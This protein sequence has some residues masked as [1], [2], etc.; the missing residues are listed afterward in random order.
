MKALVYEGP[1]M[2]NIHELPIPEIEDDE[3]LIEVRHVGIC[4]SELGG[5]LGHNSLRKP[6][7]IMGHEFSGIVRTLGSRV[8][9]LTVG[10]RVTVNPLVSCNLCI[11]CQSGKAHLCQ[12]RQLIGAQRPGAFA[13]FVTVPERNIHILPDHVSLAEGALAEPFAC[14]VHVC[15][16]LKLSPEDKLFIAGAGPIGLFILQTA[17]AFGLRDIVISDINQERLEIARELGGIAIESTIGDWKQNHLQE[18]FDA[19][20]DAVGLDI[21][22][23]ECIMSV[24]A[25]GK[26]VFTGLHEAESSLPINFAIRSEITMKGAFAYSPYDF[27]LALQWISEGKNRLLPWTVHTSLEEGKNS[28]EKLITGPG[29]ITKILLD[30]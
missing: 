7:L 22:R 19:A 18:G 8:R 15:R 10:N 25:G 12:K 28:F 23:N 6:P 29:K 26:V 14:A 27:Q 24:K 9:H 16:L 20:V 2:M 5:Y 1:R 17:Q 4:G 21:T 3:A 13:G 11:F 30:V